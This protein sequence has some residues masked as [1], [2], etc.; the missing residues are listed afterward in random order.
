MFQKNKITTYL[1]ILLIFAYTP[2]FTL[3]AQSSGKVRPK[4]TKIS[5]TC[6]LWDAI[7]YE[8]LYYQS[9]NTYLPL[10]LYKGARSKVYEVTVGPEDRFKLFVPEEGEEGEIIYKLVGV[11]PL[12][13]NTKKVLYVIFPKPADS[14]G[15]P[16][17]LYGID[18][19]FESSPPASYR[20]INFTKEKLSVKIAGKTTVV[21]PKKIKVISYKP[22]KG[23]AFEPFIV[24]DSSSK[25]VYE[26]RLICRATGRNILFILPAVKKG[27]IVK[28]RSIPQTLPV[29]D[30]SVK[31][32]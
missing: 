10:K 3:N 27:G 2:F 7:P 5:F 28:I 14:K 1:S 24:R 15:R 16:L 26:T 20:F 22:S 30:T 4:S 32:E 29:V 11:A 18:D 25:K 17:R 8:A 31:T 6:A 12:V 19:S 21:N 9:D 23:G 13:A